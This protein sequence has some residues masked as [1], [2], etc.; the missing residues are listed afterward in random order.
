MKR[1]AEILRKAIRNSPL[2]KR[3]ESTP[4]G[5]RLLNDVFFRTEISLYTG[6]FISLLY[7]GIKMC[8]G[9]HYRSLWFFSL[10]IY[11]ILLAAMRFA[12]LR[13]AR[14]HQMGRDLAYEL[15][16]YRFCGIAL[17]LM[18]QALTVIVALVVH[19]NSGFDYPGV[20]IY[21]MALYAFYTVISAAASLIANRKRGS[22]VLSAARIVKL[23][24]A[25]VSMLSLETAMLCR[26]GN[27]EN[28][29]FRRMM[30][31]ISG[32]VVCVF[33]LGMAVFML[34]RSVRQMKN[35]V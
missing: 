4:L 14:T 26:F 34:V 28:T 5:S 3:I 17:L 20:L 31:G 18:N 29:T 33:V 32:G 16:Y 25:M 6:L 9:I 30:T 24:A 19:Q 15:K 27:E 7:A 21:A 8:L 2:V 11:Y 1:I 13:A 12:L 23:T 10:S 22:P 35:M